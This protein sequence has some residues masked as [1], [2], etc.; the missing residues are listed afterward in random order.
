MNLNKPIRILGVMTGTS[1]D[2]LDA[3][4]LEIS[5]GKMKSLWQASLPYP[6]DLKKRVLEAQKPGAKFTAKEWYELHRD[7]G[8]WY[9]KSFKTLVA[10]HP[11]AKPQFI[12]NHGQ[13]VLHY[14][15]LKP[16]GI[17]V[18]LG[19]PSVIAEI[20]GLSVISNFRN[21]DVA[22][23]GEGAPLL[24]LLHHSLAHRHGLMEGIAFHNLGGFSN[25]TYLGPDCMVFAF[26]TGPANAWIDFAVEQFT[27]GKM[28]Y[29]RDGKLASMG[30]VNVTLLH[31]LLSH[32]YFKK[33]PPK[34][35]GRDD[36]TLEALKKKVKKLN[37]DTVAT[38]TELT[39]VSIANAYKDFILKKG[40]PLSEIYF[41][42]GGSFNS[43][44][45]KRIQFHLKGV[46]IKRVED[47][48]LSSSHIEAEGFAYLGYLSLLGEPI[49]G[50]WTGVKTFG[51]PG[52]ITPGENWYKL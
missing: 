48:K 43:F 38:L 16:T 14:P 19:D 47:L 22:A 33:K 23:G 7:L 30:K 51:P 25:L 40:L 50:P 21:G 39:A 15:T 28:T 41:C 46:K 17:T 1:C 10:R 8:V 6:S 26:D 4:C 44:L 9:G 29:D 37:V 27:R 35:T 12:A 52:M 3:A 18:Q 5:R 13:T 42:G 2:G 45:L 34:S 20:T 11:R 49:G 36:F 32:P 24:P 31:S